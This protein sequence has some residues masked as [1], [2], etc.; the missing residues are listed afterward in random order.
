MKTRVVDDLEEGGLWVRTYASG[1]E[2]LYTRAYKLWNN[3]KQRCQS[4][5]AIQKN[6]PTYIGCSVGENFKD[7]QFFATWCQTQIGYGVPSFELEKDLLFKGN[8]EYNETACL[9]LPQAL[10]KFL[11]RSQASR[12]DCPVGVYFSAHHG[13]YLATCNDGTGKKHYVGA[14]ET[15]SDAF[16]AYRLYKNGLAKT[17]AKTYS[18]VIDQR[19]I[20]ALMNYDVSVDD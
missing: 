2:R 7:F 10:N 1:G 5:G 16:E 20:T 11:L 15:M 8:R 19:A 17:L 14:F 9:F 12:G 4:R 6:R 3:M 13:K 18:N